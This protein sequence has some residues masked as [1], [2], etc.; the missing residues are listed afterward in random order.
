MVFH[1][2][3]SL[4]KSLVACISSPAFRPQGRLEGAAF[5]WG[6]LFYVL[7]SR[8]P[9]A[10]VGVE[11]WFYSPPCILQHS[12]QS[13]TQTPLNS[14]PLCPTAYLT[15]S[16]RC[17]IVLTL[18]GQKTP[19]L[20]LHPPPPGN[21][22]FPV[23]INDIL[24]V[25][26]VKNPGVIYDAPFSHPHIESIRKSSPKAPYTPLQP[27]RPPCRSLNTPC[28]LLPHWLCTDWSLCLVSVP[29]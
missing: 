22:L 29:F 27:L 20:C 19:P 3:I 17:L 11:G 9:W 4:V 23:S 7:P 28:T 15:S 25:A 5:W 2:V 8:G 24:P 1:L 16:P 26:Q 13:H 18:R 12:A 10:E 14:K 6:S 21:L